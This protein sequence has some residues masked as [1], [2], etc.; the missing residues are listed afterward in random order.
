VEEAG[1]T[2]ETAFVDCSSVESVSDVF[3][4]LK[5]ITYPVKYYEDMPDA[6]KRAIQ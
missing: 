1:Y 4:S 6:K 5:F 2:T 3:D